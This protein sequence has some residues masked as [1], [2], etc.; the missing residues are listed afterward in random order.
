MAVNRRVEGKEA[1][2]L[3]AP[4]KRATRTSD[5]SEKEIE[6]AYVHV[7]DR[8]LSPAL[9]KRQ[10]HSDA[11]FGGYFNLGSLQ[12][13]VIARLLSQGFANR[14][15]MRL[16]L[17]RFDVSTL[18]QAVNV[19]VHLDS[20]SYRLALPHLGESQLLQIEAAAT[21]FSAGPRLVDACDQIRVMMSILHEAA[22]RPLLA[23]V[24]EDLHRQLIPYTYF[25]R[26]QVVFENLVVFFLRLPKLLRAGR[27]EMLCAELSSTCK[28]NVQLVFPAL[29]EFRR[30][31]KPPPDAKVSRS[32]LFEAAA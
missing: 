28:Q 22:C 10:F 21:A 26:N 7:R 14:T 30:F 24:I 27:L 5:L 6:A 23:A 25:D 2:A 13:V 11:E 4:A 31:H 32:I 18:S 19:R 20:L 15:N 8:I 12:D 1:L 16:E 17:C 29:A 9:E 3:H